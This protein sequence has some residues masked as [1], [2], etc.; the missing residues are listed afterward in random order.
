MLFVSWRTNVIQYLD[1]LKKTIIRTNGKYSIRLGID[2]LFPREDFQ[3]LAVL[4][5]IGPVVGGV[6][7]AELQE[8]G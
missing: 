1:Q 4:G 7:A 2:W 3:F 5:C 6:K 8:K